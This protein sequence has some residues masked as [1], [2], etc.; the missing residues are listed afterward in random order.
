[1]KDKKGFTLTEILATLAILAIVIAIAVPSL[2]ALIKSFERKY[3]ESLEST[4]LSSAK[5]YYKDH[6]EERPTGILYSSAITIN[7]LIKNKYIDSAKVYKKNDEC[8]GYVLVVNEGEGKYNYKTCMVCN[9]DLKVKNEDDK[10]Y[11]AY[12]DNGTTK[13]EDSSEVKLITTEVLNDNVDSISNNASVVQNITAENITLPVSSEF[14]MNQYWK[15]YIDY[16]LSKTFDL[17][18]KDINKKTLFSFKISDYKPKNISNISLRAE[19]EYSVTYVA[20]GS[21]ETIPRI[22]KVVQIEKPIYKDD[23]TVQKPDTSKF[24]TSKFNFEE[25]VPGELQKLDSNSWVKDNCSDTKNCTDSTKYRYKYIDKIDNVDYDYNFYSLETDVTKKYKLT[26]NFNYDGAPDEKSYDLSTGQEQELEKVEGRTGYTFLGWFDAKEDDKGTEYKDKYVMGSKDVT[27]YAHWKTNKYTLYYWSGVCTI[28]E[29]SVEREYGEEYGDLPKS[30]SEGCTITKWTSS[31]NS[32]ARIVKSTDKM[33]NKDVTI[34][35]VGEYKKYNL[36]FDANGGFITSNGSNTLEI[37]MLYNASINNFP[38]VS[39]NG[40]T[41]LGWYTTTSGGNKVTEDEKMPAKDLTLYAQWKSSDSSNPTCNI[42]VTSGKKGNNNYY[43]SDVSI[44]LNMDDDIGVTNYGLTTNLTETYNNSYIVNNLSTTT[45]YY[46]YVKDAAGNKGNC[47]STILIDK[48]EPD[49]PTLTYTKETSKGSYTL[50]NWTNETINRYISSTDNGGS[51][52]SHFRFKEATNSNGTWICNANS[53]GYENTETL[54]ENIE[55]I[56]DDKKYQ[57]NFSPYSTN[58][59]CFQAVDKAGNASD[60]TD[61]Q[62]ILIDKKEPDIPT[63]TYTK[64]TTGGSY[65]TGNWTN[66]TIN[67]YISSTDNGGSG[68]SH[69]RFKEATNSNGTW[70]CNANSNGYENTETLAENIEQIKD[71]KKYQLNFSPYSTNRACFQAV[72]KAGNASDWTDIQEILIDKTPPFAP[73]VTAITDDIL[74]LCGNKNE[75]YNSVSFK[76]RKKYNIQGW[77]NVLSTNSYEG[78]ISYI[79]NYPRKTQTSSAQAKVSAA[80]ACFGFMVQDNEGGS[81]IAQIGIKK[82]YST[83][84]CDQEFTFYDATSMSEV[85]DKMPFDKYRTNETNFWITAKDKAGNQGPALSYT[86]AYGKYVLND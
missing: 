11:C 33:P 78:L 40:Y 13:D 66:E 8:K 31:M 47:K 86:R 25:K 64:A 80:P 63:L 30:N 9:N 53:N 15:K 2:N 37:E 69:F 49:I 27:L 45:T 60:W 21:T 14:T 54:A 23:K 6:P 19:N 35:A 5:N 56:K 85:K 3:Y 17:E 7:G 62:E 44:K 83:G 34:Y 55:Q 29:T 50:G 32:S 58:R 84:G 51:G 68:I 10:K 70:I 61:L 74:G 76:T 57:L 81:G 20:N 79:N 77:Y 59:A 71:D 65:T 46:G 73:G 48:K 39:R 67:R 42:I 22:V 41:F 28:D 75:S 43:T 12:Y 18:I 52:I 26:F 72:D 38:T 82:C 36:T 16:K 24:N 4:V 1:M